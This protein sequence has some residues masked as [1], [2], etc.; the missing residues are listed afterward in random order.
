MIFM[1]T[2][3]KSHNHCNERH[4]LICCLDGNKT[5][6]FVVIN[7]S[8]AK[9]MI[10]IIILIGY[11][12]CSCLS[13]FLCLRF[14]VSNDDNNNYTNNTTNNTLNICVCKS[15]NIIIDLKVWPRRGS[16]RHPLQAVQSSSA[17]GMWNTISLH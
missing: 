14:T 16:G 6:F 5:P 2:R 15:N 3:N 7:I 4:I 1:S 17:V 8:T 11:Y 13:H 9:T 12:S 10:T